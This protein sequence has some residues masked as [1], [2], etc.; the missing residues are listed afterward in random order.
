MFLIA[1]YDTTEG[2]K[3]K[4]TSPGRSIIW[5]MLDLLWRA[6][7]FWLSVFALLAGW[8]G[9]WGLTWLGRAFPRR[10]LLLPPPALLGARAGWRRGAAGLALTAAPALLLQVIASSFRQPRLNPLLRLVPGRYD[11]RVIA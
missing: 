9:W 4:T 6:F 7:L 8:R 1:R 11:D 10:L 3:R 5:P 2:L